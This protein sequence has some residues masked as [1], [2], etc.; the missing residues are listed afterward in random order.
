MRG[1]VSLS[2]LYHKLLT[3]GRARPKEPAAPKKRSGEI[4]KTVYE[5]LSDEGKTMRVKEIQLAVEDRLGRPVGW[6]NVKDQ[7]SV[8]SKGP[9]SRYLRISYGRYLARP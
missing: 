8:H 1:S 5:V 9:K 2:T 6:S 3:R 4:A 7:L